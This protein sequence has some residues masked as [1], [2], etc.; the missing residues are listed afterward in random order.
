[1]TCM[2]C[3]TNLTYIVI[4]ICKASVSRILLKD[5]TLRHC[6]LNCTLWLLFLMDQTISPSPNGLLHSPADH[7]TFC[8]YR[9]KSLFWDPWSAF[10][11]I[12]QTPNCRGMPGH[13]TGMQGDNLWWCAMFS[14]PRVMAC[15]R[16]ALTGEG[17][18]S[19]RW[20]PLIA[21]SNTECSITSDMY[22]ELC[23]NCQPWRRVFF[24]QC[25]CWWLLV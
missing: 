14:P 5:C 16:L 12:S 22:F 20:L 8:R 9:T 21:Q 7:R 15:L 11:A 24:N 4:D 18:Q 25:V 10:A 13:A 23:T 17:S 3:N 2:C 6:F 19:L 1:M